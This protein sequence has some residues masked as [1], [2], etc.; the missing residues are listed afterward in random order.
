MVNAVCDGN[1]P[2]DTLRRAA[3]PISFDCVMAD[4]IHEGRIGRS[5]PIRF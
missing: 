1:L 5:K 3:T 2:T 4:A